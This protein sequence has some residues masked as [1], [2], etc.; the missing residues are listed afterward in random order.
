[1][2][3]RRLTA[4]PKQRPPPGYKNW[5]DIPAEIIAQKIYCEENNL[6]KNGQVYQTRKN[7]RPKMREEK[8]QPEAPKI[9][10]W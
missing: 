2:S 3:S 6:R 10:G 9:I 8:F 4:L 1:M 5:I 7:D